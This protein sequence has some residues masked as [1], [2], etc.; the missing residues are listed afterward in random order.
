MAKRITDA[1][2][3]GQKGI[4]IIERRV[5]EMGF[6][7]NPTTAATD[8]GID[9]YIELRDPGTGEMSANILL[10]QS[11]A[12][13]FLEAET[14][15]SF[16]FTPK[17]ADLQYWGQSNAPLLLVIS[18]PETDEAWYVEIRAYCERFPS[19]KVRKVVFDK[20]K[21]RFA[22][23]TSASL[24]QAAT[25]TKPGLYFSP[26]RIRETLLT[27]LI[28]IT[29]L[30]PI[31]YMAETQHREPGKL[32][33]AMKHAGGI[34]PTEWILR[35]KYIYSVH[36][37]R[38]GA[39]P[40]FCDRGTVE[41]IDTEEWSKSTDPE[42]K[43]GFTRLLG[44]CLKSYLTRFG[45]GYRRSMDCFYFLAG[46]SSASR[47]TTYMS[48]KNITQRDVVVQL[49]NKNDPTIKYFR[50]SAFTC[51]FHRFESKWYLE[52]NPEY[53]FTTDGLLEHPRHAERQSALRRIEKHAAIRGQVLMISRLFL[54]RDDLI[55]SPY[56]FL[57]LG[58]LATVNVDCGILDDVW[59]GDG[60]KSS[61]EIASEENGPDQT[62]RNDR[63]TTL[64]QQ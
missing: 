57:G 7:W 43:R 21:D 8:A 53:V 37:L 44:C 61:D 27:N 42:T 19:A 13:T 51:Q 15:Q 39:W 9:G 32:W 56:P 63:E 41:T 20:V 34:A 33:N 11:K 18:R 31:L 5:L 10:V 54:E 6:S 49:S 48:Q 24:L 62:I 29:R 59:Q 28:S 45:V 14:E 38:D 16:E 46:Q 25:V 64:F 58:K 30:P 50:H 55:H 17:P 36:N 12:R 23:E 47:I 52:I 4:N 1:Q 2:I 60:W 3:L 26:P 22:K 40:A 35:D